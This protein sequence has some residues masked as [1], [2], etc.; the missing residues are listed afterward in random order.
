M[1]K[2]QF[3]SGAKFYVK[4]QPNTHYQLVQPTGKFNLGYLREF[5]QISG[6]PS[7]HSE[8]MNISD[9][10]FHGYVFFLGEMIHRTHS[11]NQFELC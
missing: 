7:Y 1:N 11:F 2:E 8:V 4:G 3:L 10:G 9:E 6:T 5:S